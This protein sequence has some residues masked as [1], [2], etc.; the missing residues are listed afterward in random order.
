[1]TPRAAFAAAVLA[2]L[3]FAPAGAQERL[4][5][6][7]N[8][9]GAGYEPPRLADGRP[10]LQGFWT[11][12]SLTA[13]E[14]PRGFDELVISDERA[15]ELAE[16]RARMA[17]AQLRPS[18]PTA[19]APTAG[20][21]VGGYN[22]FW[23]DPGETYA[24]VNGTVRAHWIVEPADGRIP[25][26]EEGRE[27]LETSI[28]AQRNTFTDPEIRPMAERCIV[29]FGSTGGPPMLN[30]LYNNNYQIVQSPDEVMILVEMNHDA[31]I[32]RIDDAHHPESMRRWMGDSVGRWDGDTLVVET[33]NMHP[34]ESLRLFFAQSLYIS[35][36][37]TITERFTRIADD[38][39]FYEF[40]VDDPGVVSQPWRAEMA[41]KASDKPVYEYACHE[42]NHALPG[43]LRGA[44]LEEAAAVE[45]S[46]AGEE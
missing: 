3:A 8:P 25:Y 33:T 35:E 16:Q 43:I 46:A 12:V 13:L 23:T 32:V 6:A 41:F 42:G 2:T 19:P 14:R 38:E 17:E 36:N 20:R 9:I 28:D 26:T 15:A 21:D 39:I 44:R 45:A 37:A 11:N 34:D 24:T 4:D 30:V 18:D 10:D 31:R 22:S 40:E 1:M 27:I 5:A 29:G 7:G